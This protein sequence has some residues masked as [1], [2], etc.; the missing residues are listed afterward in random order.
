M[1]NVKHPYFYP[2]FMTYNELAAVIM[3]RIKLKTNCDYADLMEYKS[4]E[5]IGA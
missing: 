5:R 2:M 1:L 4:D 3:Y